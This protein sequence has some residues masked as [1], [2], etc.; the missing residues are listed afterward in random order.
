MGEED[1]EIAGGL[2]KTEAIS[3]IVCVWYVTFL[4]DEPFPYMETN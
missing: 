3:G 4:G 1:G 2:N